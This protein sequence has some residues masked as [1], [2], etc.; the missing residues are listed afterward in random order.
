[1][2]TLPGRRLQGASGAVSDKIGRRNA[3]HRWKQLMG[4]SDAVTWPFDYGAERHGLAVL[5]HRLFVSRTLIAGPR[6]AKDWAKERQREADD[7]SD[8]QHH[9]IL[10]PSGLNDTLWFSG[11]AN[12][13]E[14]RPFPFASREVEH[15][16]EDVDHLVGDQQAAEHRARPSAGSPRRRRRWPRAS[17]RSR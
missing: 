6:Q 15:R 7:H 16:Q 17:G 13:M 4:R 10:S 3:I 2:Q 8:P 12:A 9:V 5:T 14:S 11:A 1:M